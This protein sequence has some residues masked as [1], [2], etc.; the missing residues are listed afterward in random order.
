MR[1]S[2]LFALLLAL[3]A[4]AGYGQ[5]ASLVRD[6]I[7]GS[8]EGAFP[9]ELRTAGGKVFFFTEAGIWASDGTTVGTVLLADSC[10]GCSR[11]LGNLDDT[12]LW[13]ASG[14]LGPQLWRSDGTRPGTYPL[15]GPGAAVGSVRGDLGEDEWHAFFRD[16]FYFGGCTD[17]ACA[18][19]RTDGTL[20]GTLEVGPEAFGFTPEGDRLFFLTYD[21]SGHSELR[22]TGD[23]AKGSTLLALF[24]A[25][26]RP[27]ALTAAEGRLFFIAKAQGD[28]LWA[29]DGTPAGTRAVTD[30]APAEPFN[31]HASAIKPAGRRAYFV[32]DDVIHG[33]EIWISDGTPQGT[34]RATEFG[35][36]EPVE[37]NPALMEEVD[38]KL[39]FFAFDGIHPPW[40]WSTAGSPEST[41]PLPACP[42]C[43]IEDPVLVKAGSR[44]LFLARDEDH[45][46]EPWA[47]D[48]T[49]AGTGRVADICPGNCSSLSDGPQLLPWPGGALLLGA[50]DGIHGSELWLSNG[51]SEG[52][53]RITDVAGAGSSHVSSLRP[54]PLDGQVWFS[55]GNDRGGLWVTDGA[56]E[57]TRMVAELGRREQGS[58]PAFLTASGSRLYF[59]ADAPDIGL[60]STAGTPESTVLVRNAF[61]EGLAAAGGLAYFRVWDEL[62]RTD[63]TAAGTFVLSTDPSLQKG[64]V[65]LDERRFFAGGNQLWA[66]DGT[67]QGTHPVFSHA[68]T[69]ESL[70]RLS[71]AG[72]ALFFVALDEQNR[73]EL[74]TSNGTA[75]GT[76][77][78]RTFDSVGEPEPVASGARIFFRAAGRIWKTDGSPAGTVQV[79]EGQRGLDATHLTAF[80]EG[81]AF[82]GSS[83][84]GRR[85]LWWTDGSAAGTVELGSFVRPPRGLTSFAG[86]LFFAADDGEHGTELWTS[87]GTAAGT[88]LLRDLFPGW[89]S[90]SPEDLTVA[91]GRLFFAAA[92]PAHG[93]ELWASD[94]TAVGTRLVQDLN[95]YAHSSGPDQLTVAGDRL[96]FTADDGLSGRE[97]W[98]FPLAEGPDCQPTSARLCLNDGRFQVEAA[99][100]DFQGGR[101]TGRAVALTPDT[102]YFW[103]FS[104]SNVEAVLKV[105][106]GRGVNDH[107]WVFYGA[108][109]N[110]EYHLTVT[111]TR[112]GAARR[113]FNP[114]G[115]LASVGDTRGF[116]PLGAF[117]RTSAASGTCQPTAERLCL[118]GGR[119]AVEA[120]W[121]D[122]QG[123]QGK[124][125]AV[126]LT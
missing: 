83:E 115:Q 94:G 52:T 64:G 117:S 30:L 78:L 34:R 121:K 54:V 15:S 118:N 61:F 105:L 49:A 107:F 116:G 113:Y 48:G 4:T 87:D 76:R 31:R 125:K 112:T 20:E 22:V 124:G 13:L 96:Y 100:K 65:E 103:F 91:G 39:V 3:V 17:G 97:L 62:W 36:H 84:F 37:W 101:G 89:R 120:S 24:D 19:W 90:S 58:A 1:S 26:D 98:Y 45:G 66:S 53:R 102:G 42:S 8:G 25:F 38:G 2:L 46:H 75:A 79:V 72:G 119:F 51:T 60:W 35:F 123:N 56:P 73:D 99:W 6:L 44:L 110:V 86:R 81:L 32:A 14:D 7:A 41:S 70:S 28:E 104:P 55:P 43:R 85:A 88:V 5:T 74:W 108:L 71:E 126:D 92:D 50:V 11:F 16:A 57:T 27:K 114:P 111:D 93:I 59:R 95:P 18:T 23:L 29:S 12:V 10:T 40:L 69:N 47:T 106:D 67:V 68:N 109:S 122:F 21:D 82:F 77:K 33:R 63:G 9:L 80:R